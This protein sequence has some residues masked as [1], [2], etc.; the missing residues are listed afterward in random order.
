M[1]GEDSM[2]GFS[3]DRVGPQSLLLSLVSYLHPKWV[4]I[5]GKINV[6]FV[7]GRL[8]EKNDIL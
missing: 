3:L 2:S 7:D 5:H 1:R 6:I 4:K 8:T